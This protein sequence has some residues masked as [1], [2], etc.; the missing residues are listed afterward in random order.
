MDRVFT[1]VA[2]Q[3]GALTAAI[4]AEAVVALN[5]LGAK[6]AE[7]IWLA[8][9][10]AAD[11]PFRGLTHT[12]AE[13]AVRSVL[14]GLPL[15]MAAQDAKNRKKRLLLADMDSTIVTTETLDDLAAHVG[16]KTQIAALTAKAMNGEL[17]FESA[18][19][20]R[21]GMLAG[22]SV[23]TLA[24]AYAEIELTSGAV[25]LVQTMRANGARCVLVSGG[26][27][28]FTSRVAEHCGFHMDQ[29]NDFV[30]E[31]GILTGEV[32]LPI[33]NKDSKLATLSSQIANLGLERN[34]TLAVGDGANDLPMIEA[35]G[36]GVAFHGKAVV[37]AAAPVRIDQTGL[38]TLLFYQGYHRAEFT[39]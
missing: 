39:G 4:V 21:V 1:I 8:N 18:V 6:T 3:P 34:E 23:Q 29:A 28:Y 36:L 22:M 19:I 13:G 5:G 7:I 37:A 2:P 20:E 15:D 11:I 14:D 33:Q 38:A 30:I 25:T 27:K 32:V 26:F 35:A 16:K 31:D 24:A 12:L 10:E 9:E 17:N